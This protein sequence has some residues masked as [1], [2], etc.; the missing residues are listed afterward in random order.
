MRA[1]AHGKL[2]VF[3]SGLFFLHPALCDIKYIIGS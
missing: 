1:L 3:K 2:A